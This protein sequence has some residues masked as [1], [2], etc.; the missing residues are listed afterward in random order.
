MLLT[1]KSPEAFPKHKGYFFVSESFALNWY[2]FIGLPNKKLLRPLQGRLKQNFLFDLED[3]IGNGVSL[4]NVSSNLCFWPKLGIQI[5]FSLLSICT[6]ELISTPKI[7]T[8]L[9]LL[10]SGNENSERD[11]NPIP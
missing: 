4:V 11:S 2:I 7:K 10:P 9:P 6:D 3:L 5:F 1:E 8:F